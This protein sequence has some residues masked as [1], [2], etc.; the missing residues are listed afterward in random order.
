MLNADGLVASLRTASEGLNSFKL[1]TAEIDL[2]LLQYH[3][4]NY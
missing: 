2:P 1:E 4:E 3:Y